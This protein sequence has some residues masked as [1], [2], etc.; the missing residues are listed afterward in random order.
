MIR[1][2]SE[3]DELLHCVWETSGFDCR[4]WARSSLRRRVE[5]VVTAEGLRD[6]A[7]LCERVRSDEACLSRLQ[8]ELARR[9]V[10][11]FRQPRFFQILRQRLVPI[12]RTYPWIH[13]WCPG[14]STGEQVWALAIVLRE[15]GLSDRLRIWATDASR[16]ALDVA[17]AGRYSLEA[18]RAEQSLYRQAGGRCSMREYFAPVG[19]EAVMRPL[20]R[21]ALVFAQHDVAT[22]GSFREFQ[23]VV[24]R[25]AMIYWDARLQ[26]RAFALFHESLCP[27]GLLALGRR[28]S[29]R[30]SPAVDRY[31]VVDEEARVYRRAS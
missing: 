25:D 11:M 9:E 31:D 16:A 26:T 22:D 27:L 20:L 12:L 2:D 23:M 6:V 14:C 5:R 4:Q 7:E 19:H 24:C 3:V 29:L 1:A 18:L 13:V 28:E 10:A 30:L 8:R 17:R 21:D 15:E